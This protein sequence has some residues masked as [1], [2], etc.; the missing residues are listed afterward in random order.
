M[1]RVS[2]SMGH[3]ALAFGDFELIPAARRLLRAGVPVRVGSRSL[4]ILI[5]LI[6]RRGEIL[7]KD[8][9]I[10][11]VWPDT[12]VEES[13]LRVHISTLR[14]ALGDGEGDVRLIANVPGR[15]YGFVAPVTVT[16]A[17][18][19]A[20]VEGPTGAALRLL[21][22]VARIIGREDLIESLA[23]TLR[24]Q[25]L[26][27]I[28]GPGGIGKTTVAVAVALRLTAADQEAVF[29]DFAPLADPSLAPGAVAS[30]LGLAVRSTDLIQEI[31]EAAR[32]RR[33]I[34]LL[35]SCE[36]LIDAVAALA[37]ALLSR[38]PGITL[39]ATSREALRADGEWVHR[40]APLDAPPPSATLTADEALAYP[41]VQMF[42]ARASAVL[43]GYRLDDGDAPVVAEICRRLDGIAL[44]IE[45]ATGRLDGMS[46]E[47]L[48][49]S[50]ENCFQ[51][52]TRGRRTAL[53]R[54][55]TLRGTIDWSFRILPAAEQALLRR[56]A[57][58]NG[59]FT[60]GAAE[61]IAGEGLPGAV[62]DGLLN[63]AAKSLINADTQAGAA[64]YR[65]LDT[66]RAYAREKLDAAGE[67]AERRRRHA[68]YY[69][70]LFAGAEADWASR[71]AVGLA[72]SANMLGNLRAAL[73]W[74]FSEDGDG[75]IG[76]ALV[77][78]AVPLWFQ[79]SLVDECLARVQAAL[80]W[81]ES[82][83][84][85]DPRVRMRL[86]A[87]LGFPQMRA[88]TGFPSGVAAWRSVL[89]I[90]E[91]IGDTDYQA[92]G[93]WALWTDR[94]N[95]GEAGEALA[96]A[97]RFANLARI[98]PDDADPLIAQRVR[99]WSLLTLGRLEAAH[100]DITLML[101][102]YGP[103]QRRSD[104][105]RFQYDQR[106]TAR[107]T[108]ARALWL[109]G[110]A[111][112]A[113]A[114][115][116]D[117][118]AAMTAADHTLSLAHVLSDAAC[119]LALWRGD[120]DLAE[121]Y[122]A[123]LRR[124]TGLQALDVWHTYGDCFEGEIRVRRGDVKA[125][126]AL[127]RTGIAQLEAAGFVC[128]HTAFL[129]VLAEALAGDGQPAAALAMIDGALAQGER[130]GEAWCR[131]EL[132]RIR[133]EILLRLDR[134][135]E[136]D[137]CLVQSLDLAATQ[138][139]LAWELRAATSRARLAAGPGAAR[140]RLA[141]VVARFRE[142]FETADLIAANTLLGRLGG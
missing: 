95:S 140:E 94:V 117:N 98:A 107:I 99:A 130:T 40:L 12:I 73:D 92:R 6:E 62:E 35:D 43:G 15:G 22:P 115:V 30:A 2:S 135:D 48:A 58:F 138:G 121:R 20:V 3:E 123:L 118:V 27:T 37:E 78:D 5:A 18:A 8:A 93:L 45:L 7:G 63:L 109:R 96:L 82:S 114:E 108:L 128:Y 26:V 113:L 4:D 49:R 70:D 91:A 69:R 90:A 72:D 51:V 86:Y 14:K 110:D 124:H 17:A 39:L 75:D 65:L 68:V 57:V 133:A 97:D 31:A 127:L 67:G 42:V 36:H 83:P 24:E 106:S 141:S 89:Q 132:L 85:P 102:A 55:Q 129:G 33:L 100:T 25:R 41:A 80:A 19:A 101:R 10:A 119:F 23:Q 34:L 88:I 136:A 32:G 131:P 71:P 21:A 64:R 137:L 104:L 50:L 122:T 112:Q 29:V 1:A 134:R 60:L 53:P 84:D 28:V 16:A 38:A 103:S 47:T 76:V 9:L 126:I 116:A 79:L 59:P 120:L 125:G 74:A 13:A 105:A 61:Q 77:A 44:A 87:G 52:L 111:D 81:L 139:A 11:L 66:T 46:L 56:L 142:G 54:H